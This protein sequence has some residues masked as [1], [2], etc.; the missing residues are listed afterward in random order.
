M[1]CVEAVTCMRSDS[2]KNISRVFLSTN[3]P[4]HGFARWPVKPV[5]PVEPV[6]VSIAQGIEHSVFFPPCALR[7]ALCFPVP[8]S[9]FRTPHSAFV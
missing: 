3:M 5:E 1:I 4:L 7:F 6:I 8:Y 9:E 2:V